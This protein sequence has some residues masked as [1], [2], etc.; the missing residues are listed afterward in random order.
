M[1]KSLRT[2]S[3]VV[4]SVPKSLGLLSQT[5]TE[6]AVT[7][8][9]VFKCGLNSYETE[10]LRRLC[11]SLSKRSDYISECVRRSFWLL[12]NWLVAT[13]CQLYR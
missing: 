3:P 4:G 2:A 6:H 11:E 12:E 1:G 5:V 10:R 7:E 8:Q 13:G 9:P